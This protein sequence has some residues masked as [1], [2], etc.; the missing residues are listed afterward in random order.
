[1]IDGRNI[2]HAVGMQFDN[3]AHIVKL[4]AQVNSEYVPENK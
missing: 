3:K 4:L 2:V 1:M